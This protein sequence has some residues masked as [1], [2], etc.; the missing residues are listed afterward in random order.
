MCNVLT[1]PKGAYVVCSLYQS[2]RKLLPSFHY[3]VTDFERFPY[4]MGYIHVI[5]IK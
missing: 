4:C 3:I 2:I 5:F 1:F